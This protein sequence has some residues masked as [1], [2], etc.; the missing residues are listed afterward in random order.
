MK[1]VFTLDFVIFPISNMWSSI[2]QNAH[3]HK[4][5]E[6]LVNPNIAASKLYLL[7]FCK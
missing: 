7:D 1:A 4:P 5:L 2:N 6:W 3:S